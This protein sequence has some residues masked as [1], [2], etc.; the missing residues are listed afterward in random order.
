MS[1]LSQHP[2]FREFLAFL[3]RRG[4]DHAVVEHSRTYTAGA[5]ARIAAVP[6]AHTAKTVM[7]RDGDGWVMAVVPA[8][9]MVDVR[10]VR[11]CMA[12]PRLQ[13]AAERDMEAAFGA[14]EVGA[15]PPFGELFDCPEAIDSRLLGA[16]RVL[17]NGGDH[18]HSVVLNA[19][20]LW[21]ASGARSGDLVTEHGTARVSAPAAR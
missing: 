16:S 8:S 14:F 5:E 1:H 17:C 21:Y 18:E 13:V 7:L 11:R 3:D 10:K 19:R 2:G 20:E 12:R 6:P 15:L 9:E 4:L